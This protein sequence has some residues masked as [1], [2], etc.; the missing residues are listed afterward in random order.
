MTKAAESSK[1]VRLLDN[2]VGT[3]QR[4]QRVHASGGGA[5]A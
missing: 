1:V 3:N 2:L 5:A 4:E